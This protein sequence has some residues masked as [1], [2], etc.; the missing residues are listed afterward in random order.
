MENFLM[1][2][3]KVFDKTPLENLWVLEI[4]IIDKS[5][6]FGAFYEDVLLKTDR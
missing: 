5:H 6:E 2:T 3:I 1:S 4:H